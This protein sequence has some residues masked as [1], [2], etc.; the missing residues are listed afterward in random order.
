MGSA[1]ID[2]SVGVFGQTRVGL[3]TAFERDVDAALA[4][5]ESVQPVV[6]ADLLSLPDPVQRY[7]RVAGV[8]GQPRVANL[9]ARM[10]GR[11]RNGRDA[12]WIPLTA[13]QYNFAHPP[14]RFFY[15]RGSMFAVPVHGYH[16]YAGTSAA[17]TV[18]AAGL[19]TVVDAAGEEMTV[20]E[21]VTLFNDMCIMAP[22]MLLDAPIVWEP[23]DDHTT[24]ARFSNAGHRPHDRCDALVRGVRRAR[25][26]SVRRPA[27]DL[28]G[29]TRRPE[30]GLVDAAG[31]LSMVRI[32]AAR[33]R[34]RGTLARARRR[35]RLHRADVRHGAVQRAMALA[36]LT[37]F[38]HRLRCAGPHALKNRWHLSRSI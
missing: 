4:R 17:M 32:R 6:D 33:I 10:H 20:G 5:I 13:E 23:V 9:Y 34:R 31:C 15:L 18:K 3:R 11:I 7:L 28:A 36:Q 29:W 21:T 22:A 14:A 26:L 12:R 38:R 24:R 2:R 35:V 1:V 19:V 27:A 30:D 8:V 37:D 16:R 25:R